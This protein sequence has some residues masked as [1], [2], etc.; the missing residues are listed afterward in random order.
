MQIPRETSPPLPLSLSLSYMVAKLE[1][2]H[3]AT[4]VYITRIRQ[5]IRITRNNQWRIKTIESPPL[6]PP[7][8]QGKHHVGGDVEAIS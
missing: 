8:P 7:P 5:N 6:T 3:K 4:L 2:T 1:R